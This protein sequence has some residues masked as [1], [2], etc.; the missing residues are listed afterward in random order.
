MDTCDAKRIPSKI[1]NVIFIGLRS[2]TIPKGIW[3]N[4]ISIK[5]EKYNKLNYYVVKLYGAVLKGIYKD[6]GV[7]SE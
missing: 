1:S 2:T 6:C 5:V 7:S 3:K 4:A